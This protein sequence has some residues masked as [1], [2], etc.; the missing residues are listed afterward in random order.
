M[1]IVVE[2]T[3][4]EAMYINRVIELSNLCDAETNTHGVLGFE[5]LTKMLLEDV[6]AMVRRPG[7]WEASHMS[8]VFAAHGYEV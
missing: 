1:K 3:D 8:D 6:A 5:K 7:C 2:I 4:D